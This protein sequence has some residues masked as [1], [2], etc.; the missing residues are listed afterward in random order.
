MA[1]SLSLLAGEDTERMV[2][3]EMERPARRCVLLVTIN[4][5]PWSQIADFGTCLT[6][7]N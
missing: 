4:Q 3:M 1:L 7:A 5:C 2:R 6:S